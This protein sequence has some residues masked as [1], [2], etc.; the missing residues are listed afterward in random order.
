MSFLNILADM[1]CTWH[2][3]AKNQEYTGKNLKI[4]N[5]LCKDAKF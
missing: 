3:E 2:N 5:E 4:K 1:Y